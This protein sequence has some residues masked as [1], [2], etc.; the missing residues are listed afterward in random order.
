[1]KKAI[2]IVLAVL[3]LGVFTWRVFPSS[4]AGCFGATK[5][6]P[7]TGGPSQRIPNT[8]KPKDAVSADHQEIPSNTAPRPPSTRL[9]MLRLRKAVHDGDLDA[10]NALGG[11]LEVGDAAT[12]YSLFSELPTGISQEIRDKLMQNLVLLLQRIPGDEASG[13]L[14]SALMREGL[15]T[16]RAWPIVAYL[17]GQRRFA[18]A[19]PYL[20]KY[21]Y[22]MDSDRKVASCGALLLMSP[23][24][25]IPLVTQHIRA[26]IGS[27]VVWRYVMAIRNV[28]SPSVDIAQAIPCL[29][30]LM[31]P[32]VPDGDRGRPI[33]AEI[34]ERYSVFF[35]SSSSKEWLTRELHL[36]LNSSDTRYGSEERKRYKEILTRLE[37]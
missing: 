11:E 3:A 27:G 22:G 18:Q 28:V 34:L 7:R 23:E 21:A 26:E 17:L 9:D 2:A 5:M 6:P 25:H 36:I 30:E 16:E 20:E 33:V 29:Q 12:L 24:T 19:A 8:T 1:M 15:L 4:S 35:K 10:F 14:H 13:Y 31:R 37:Q 32:T